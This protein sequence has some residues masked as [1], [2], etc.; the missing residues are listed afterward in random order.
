MAS[1]TGILNKYIGDYDTLR[2]FLRYISLG[3]YNK[4]YFQKHLGINARTYEDNLA[5][6]RF[7]LPD[8]AL[9]THRDGHKEIY[10]LHS[11]SYYSANNYLHS[12]YQ[13][14]NLKPNTAFYLISLLQIIENAPLP[15]T[16]K[17][18]YDFHLLPSGNTCPP[19]MLTK[20]GFLDISFSTMKRYLGILAQIGIIRCNECTKPKSYSAKAN[21]FSQLSPK[22]LQELIHA[23]K[24]YIAIA[25][26]GTLGYQMLLILQHIYSE[27]TTLS[28]PIQ[29]KHKKIINTL[30]DAIVYEINQAIKQNTSILFEY[31]DKTIQAIPIHIELDFLTGRQY[32]NAVIKRSAG[33]KYFRQP[34]TYRLDIIKN[35]RLQDIDDILYERTLL[36]LKP[37]PKP[38]QLR[39]TY[40]SSLDKKRLSYRILTRYPQAKLEQEDEHHF[41]C[42]LLLHDTLRILPW[43][44]T[45]YPHV[46]IINTPYLQR[47]LIEDVKE[48]LANYDQYTT[49]P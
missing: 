31:G 43:I 5:R 14:K 21:I 7:F 16:E 45:L 12:I 13:I 47:R 17:Q 20:D 25:P 28:F 27:L 33:A 40:M 48:A 19:M 44:K 10:S 2:P 39:I 18:I 1:S 15:L 23:I 41:T 34:Q 4:Q 35:I 3:C 29:F 32:L 30:D 24:Y 9:I 11:D 37:Q 6:L 8:S 42:T 38:V 49:I 22:E 46:E 26:M 36:Q